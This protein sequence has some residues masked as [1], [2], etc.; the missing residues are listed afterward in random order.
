VATDVE[1]RAVEGGKQD[2][3]RRFEGWFSECSFCEQRE[4][5]DMIRGQLAGKA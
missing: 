4:D 3:T 1:P 5:E 2:E